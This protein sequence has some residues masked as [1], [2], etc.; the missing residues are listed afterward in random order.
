MS[1]T[2][3]GAGQT[4]KQ[5]LIIT[6][7]SRKKM[8]KKIQLLA[9]QLEVIEQEDLQEATNNKR[10][11]DKRLLHFLLSLEEHQLKR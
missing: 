6:K 9:P 2:R 8:K 7:T 11:Q 10:E 3:T 4:D 5:I 1:K